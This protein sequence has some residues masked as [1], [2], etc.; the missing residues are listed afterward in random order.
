MRITILLAFVIV[1]AACSSQESSNSSNPEPVLSVA[2]P[3]DFGLDS[4]EIAD[5]E[6][7]IQWAIDSSFISGAVALI[8]K[9]DKI[10]YHKAFGHSDRGKSSKMT[11][12]HIFRLASMT[13]PITSTAV[14]QLVEQG[15]IALDDPVSKYIPEFSDMQ[16]I[17]TWDESDSSFTTVPAVREI[18]IHHLITHTSGIAYSLFHPVGWCCCLSLGV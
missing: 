10:I 18:T 17:D 8:A 11:T 16:V 9:D 6:S 13:K 2:N 12:D 14:M 15:E 7:H 1:M 3:G 4:E 5:I